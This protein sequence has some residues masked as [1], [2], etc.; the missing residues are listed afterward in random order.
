MLGVMVLVH[1]DDKGL[2]IPPKLAR[3]QV[4]IILIYNESN[5]AKVL[6]KAKEVESGI[7]KSFRTFMDTND[8]TS[9]GW[10]FHEWELRGVPV[11]L[12]IGEKDIAAG[13]VVLVRRDTGEKR[14]VKMAEVKKEIEVLL[15][16]I[17]KNLYEK[18]SKFLQENIHKASDYAELKKMIKE[19][20]GFVR[21]PW[22]DRKTVRR[23]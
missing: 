22:C 18:A 1:G 7:R 5:T 12:E 3:I 6:E 17:H 2:V 19:K 20:G 9:P 14:A 4:V 21:A 10:K 23:R 11:R 15:K 16:E 13:T 8:S